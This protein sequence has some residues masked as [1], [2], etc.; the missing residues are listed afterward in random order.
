MHRER[1]EMGQFDTE[2][3]FPE[4]FVFALRKWFA[5]VVDGLTSSVP[6]LLAGVDADAML[7]IHIN[8]LYGFRQQNPTCVD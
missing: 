4:L 7:P 3:R 2:L 6:G 5:L 1:I 8:E